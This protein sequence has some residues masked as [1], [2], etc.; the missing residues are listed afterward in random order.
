MFI[1]FNRD[2]KKNVN[3]KCKYMLNKIVTSSTK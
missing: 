1:I 2:E 3:T